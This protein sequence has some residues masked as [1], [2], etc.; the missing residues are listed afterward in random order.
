MRKLTIG[1]V[2]YDDYDGFYFSIQAIRMY[3]KEAL[4]DIEF[5]IIN[6]NSDSPQGQAVEKFC[7]ANW[8]K[9]PFQ[10]FRD[11]N[12]MGTA[13]RSKIFDYA[14]TPYVLI[15]D[16]H[17]MIEAGG[18]KA[19]I[20]YF[21]NG[22]DDGNL[23]QAP[24][25]YDNLE[26]GPSYFKPEWRD[27]MFGTWAMDKRSKGNEPFEIPSQGLG[28]FACRKDAWLGFAKGHS[29]FG[30]EEGVCHEKF[31]QSG[32]KTICFP[33]LKWLHKFTRVNGCPYPNRYEDRVKNYF[34]GHLE[35]NQPV[36]EIIEH[37][38]TLGIQEET[39]RGWL[40]TVINSNA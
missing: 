13:T 24:L 2:V 29:G 4:N 21:S 3:H 26:D 25:L 1:M 6:T 32:K 9:E 39:L 10:Y 30:G 35:L 23:I 18:I 11:D 16:S 27:G 15:M 14:K 28:V 36:F 37:F 19:L 7:V 17:V 12:K 22:E 40:L 31:R 38:K 33:P 34:R 20:D 5:V 8:I